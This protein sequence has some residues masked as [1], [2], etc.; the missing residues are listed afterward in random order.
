MKKESIHNAV[1]QKSWLVAPLSLFIALCLCL[2]SNAQ[3]STLS[4]EQLRDTLAKD[5]VLFLKVASKQLKWEVPAEP[6]KLIGP[7]YFV[8][9]QGLSSFLITSRQGH[10]LLYTGMPSSG[11]MIEKS[12]R[13]LGFKPEDIK[14]II[15]GHAHSDHVGG[16]A[17]MKKITGARIALMGAEKELLESGGKT[18]FHYGPYKEYWFEPVKVDQVLHERDSIQVGNLKMI[19][20]HTGGHTKGGTTWLMDITENGKTYKIV[21]PDGTSINPGYR[22]GANPSYPGIADNYRKTLEV[23]EKLNPDIWFSSHTDF[24]DFAGKSKLAATKGSAVWIDPA[25]YKKRIASERA[26][27]NKAIKEK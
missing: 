1:L 3:L 16:H 2:N 19:A 26:N 4:K 14:V 5:P 18:D 9:T 20:I 11:P 8:G 13:K 6:K 17:Y 12:I 10:I 7:I 15:T 21:F 27:F 22:L 23:L 25:G 24:F